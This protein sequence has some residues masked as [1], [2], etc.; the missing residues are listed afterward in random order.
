M[1]FKY[2]LLKRLAFLIFV[3]KA[4]FR[5]CTFEIKFCLCYVTQIFNTLEIELNVNLWK[6]STWFAENIKFKK[7]YVYLELESDTDLR[8]WCMKWNKM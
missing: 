8:W 2:S 6:F 1:C 4:F 5:K 3:I 7:N